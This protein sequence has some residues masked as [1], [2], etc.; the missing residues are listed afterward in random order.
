MSFV[1][2]FEEGISSQSSFTNLPQPKECLYLQSYIAH[3]LKRGVLES[4]FMIHSFI[5]SITVPI[6][7]YDCFCL[8]QQIHR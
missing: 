1:E 7:S 4:P 2:Y 8:S 3:L 5:R 6:A